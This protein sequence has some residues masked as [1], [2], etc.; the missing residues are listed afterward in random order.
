MKEGERWCDSGRI[1]AFFIFIPL[2][3]MNSGYIFVLFYGYIR[4]TSTTTV[5]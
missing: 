3:Y 1:H 4:Y 2:L 5:G